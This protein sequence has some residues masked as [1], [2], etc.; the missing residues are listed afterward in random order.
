MMVKSGIVQPN[1]TPCEHCGQ[2]SCCMLDG[3][4]LCRVH[5]AARPD[6]KQASRDIKLKSF[7]Q[8]LEGAT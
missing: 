7:D 1:T 3:K 5:A 4:P 6:T 2:P 8:P